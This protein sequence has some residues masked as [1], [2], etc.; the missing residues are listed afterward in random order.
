MTPGID[1]LA[2]EVGPAE[3]AEAAIE[4]MMEEHGDG[5]LRL[6]FM[7]LGDRGLAE[8]AAQEVFWRAHRSYH[9]FRGE[10]KE[11]TWLS[12]IAINCCRSAQRKRRLR[13]ETSAQALE[14]IPNISGADDHQD[15]TVIEKVMNLSPKYKEAVL[16]HYYQGF[17][18]REIAGMLRVPVATVTSRL[19]RAREKLKG[20][21]KEW[22]DE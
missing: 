12:A 14:S 22:Y 15:D 13:I 7:M 17:H 18:V 3:S 4:R 19:R 16:L 21:L 6:C 10:S 2:A 20:E 11:Y 9:T 8:D 1:R 5:I